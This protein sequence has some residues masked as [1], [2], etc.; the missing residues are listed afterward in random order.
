MRQ[1]VAGVIRLAQNV[2]RS[3]R[4]AELVETQLRRRE[5][6]LQELGVELSRLD[7]VL[8]RSVEVAK[9]DGRGAEQHARIWRLR[10]E[11]ACVSTR[12]ESGLRVTTIE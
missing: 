2:A 10:K 3:A 7:V 8:Q 4:I 1:C 6:G 11:F 12:G 5:L 9:G